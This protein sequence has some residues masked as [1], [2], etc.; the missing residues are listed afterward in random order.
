MRSVLY[1]DTTQSASSPLNCAP[2]KY[3]D[4]SRSPGIEPCGGLVRSN[5]RVGLGGVPQPRVG[6]VSSIHNDTIARSHHVVLAAAA[7]VTILSSSST[8]LSMTSTLPPSLSR[9]S[10]TWPAAVGASEGCGCI[11]DTAAALRT[12]SSGVLALPSN[13]GATRLSASR[14]RC[15]FSSSRERRSPW[16]RAA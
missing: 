2:K 1:D 10:E 5:G 8:R 13:P 15:S 12:G 14:R 9:F 4:R 3:I 7:V 16:R 6:R 11:S